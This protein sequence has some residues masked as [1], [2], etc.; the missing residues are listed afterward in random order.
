MPLPSN[1]LLANKYRIEAII[2][3][4]AYGRVYRARDVQLDRL[5]AIKELHKGDGE[6]SSTAYNDYA[7]RFRREAK[8]QARFDHPHIVHVYELLEPEPDKLYL[9]MACVDGGTLKD[10]IERKGASLPI[11]D[12]LRIGQEILQGLAYVHDDPRDIV[13]R[14]IKPS[15]I[16]LT[17]DGHAKTSDF[18]LAQVGDESMRSGSGEPHPG[19]AMYM[20]PEQETTPAYL[21]PQ[22]DLF[23]AG[24]VLFE[25]L[26]GVPYKKA[27]RNRQSL[28]DLRPDVPTTLDELIVQALLKDYEAR[29]ESAEAMAQKLGVGGNKVDSLSGTKEQEADK[30]DGPVWATPNAQRIA[31]KVARRE[32]RQRI[33]AEEGQRIAA[34]EVRMQRMRREAQ[35][36]VEREK[37]EKTKRIEEARNLL[38]LE[39]II[40]PAGE[41]LYGDGNDNENF[42]SKLFGRMGKRSVVRQ[43]RITKHPI[44]NAQYQFFINANPQ[45]PVPFFDIEWAMPYNWNKTTRQHPR[46]KANH[47]VVFVSWHDTQVFC[48]WA[49]LRLPSQGEWEKAAR[50]TDGRIYPWGHQTPT[51][52]L[53]NFNTDEGSTTPIGKYSPQGDSPYGCVDMSGNVWEWTGDEHGV[54]NRVPGGAAYSYVV[55]GGAWNSD[56]L[57]VRASNL[58]WR[59]ASDIYNDVGFR[60]ASS[61]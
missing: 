18:G 2:G 4:G 20:S 61:P 39:W 45:H 34:D 29:P 56:K 50:G 22:S 35:E 40:I 6:L 8:V 42:L 51:N 23:S 26:T 54:Y 52:K 33:D 15:N 3:Q 30:S 25:L 9:V 24:C 38:K 58:Y 47:P 16:L 46:D 57:S 31:A 43:F 41:F 36:R 21:Y 27:K 55:R 28:R 19:T 1:T 17:K 13:H 14:D 10:L 5:V 12:V 49:G 60:C 32:M 37:W 11:D 53:C 48:Q 59:V 7:R 44:T